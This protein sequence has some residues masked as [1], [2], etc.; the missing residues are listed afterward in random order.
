ML[1]PERP[2][3]TTGQKIKATT[4]QIV[5]TYASVVLFTLGIILGFVLSRL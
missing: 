1:N 3:P 2:E 4:A 5:K